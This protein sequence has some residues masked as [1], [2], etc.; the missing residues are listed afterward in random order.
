MSCMH[1][2]AQYYCKKDDYNSTKPDTSMCE[3]RNGSW[4]GTV[5]FDSYYNTSCAEFCY[6]RNC[7]NG[8]WNGNQSHWN[9]SHGNQSHGNYSHGNDSYGNDTDIIRCFWTPMGWQGWAWVNKTDWNCSAYCMHNYCKNQSLGPD[10]RTCPW[11][12]NTW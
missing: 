9:N 3:M 10:T 12:N 4:A 8:S 11:L 5:F 7:G 1:F 2:C 6:Y